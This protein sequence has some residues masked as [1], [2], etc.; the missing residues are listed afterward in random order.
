M[1]ITLAVSATEATEAAAG[2]REK[3][4]PRVPRIDGKRLRALPFSSPPAPFEG[5]LVMRH[6]RERERQTETR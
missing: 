5:S 1:P 6:V 3:T 4:L 2:N